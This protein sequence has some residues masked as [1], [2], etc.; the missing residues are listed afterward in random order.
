MVVVLKKNQ[1]VCINHQLLIAESLELPLD[2]EYNLNVV[3]EITTTD[4]FLSLDESIRQ[5]QEESYDECTTRKYM[6]TL[7]RNC[8]CL[9]FKLRLT[10]E[11]GKMYRWIFC[12]IARYK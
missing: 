3:E 11:V 10:D 8:Q 6:N 2:M 9:P 4:S 1:K 7:I 5:C 12:L